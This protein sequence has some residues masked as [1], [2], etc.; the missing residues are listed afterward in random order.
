MALGKRLFTE[1]AA[2]CSTETTDIFG[3]STGKV[4]YSMDFDASSADRSLDATATNV[5]FGVSGRTVNAA[6]FKADGNTSKIDLPDILPA[7]SNADSSFTCWFRT[8]DT[9]GTQQTIVNAWN[10]STTANNGGWALFKD[11][12]NTFFFG[13]YYLKSNASGLTG[14]TALGDGNWH[15]VAVIFDYSAGTLS[16]YLD[17]NSTPHLQ[18]TSLTPGTVNIFN[19]GAELGY[20]KPGP[21]D[22]AFIGDIDQVRVFSKVLSQSEMDTLYNSGNG[23][24]ACVH[25]AT[26]DNND[27]P[28]TNAAYYK[29]N[30]S[31]E[32]SHSGTYDGTE[33]DIQYRFGKYNQAAVFNG[34]SSLIA[35]GS[36]IPNTDT[37]VAIS[38]W[39]K[40][41]SGISGNMHITGTGITTAASEAPFRATLQYQ[42]ANTFRLFAL[43]QVGGTYYLADNSTLTNVTMIPQIWYHVV[44][45]YN[46]TGRQLSTFLNG[47][48][49]DSNK[50]MSTSGSSVDDSTTVIGSFRSTSGP[51]FD[52]DIDQL[53]IFTSELS[54]T[55]VTSLYNEKPE[56]DT[57]NFKTVLYK[58]TGTTGHFINNVGM[59][60]ETDGG[61]VWIKSR[62]DSLG[63]NHILQ[64]HVRGVS[65]FIMTPSTSAESASDMVTS[66]EKTG[67]FLGADTPTGVNTNNINFV[68]WVWKAGGAT[69]ENTIGDITSQV[70]LNSTLG[71]SI[72]SYTGDANQSNTIGHG[73]KIG[74]TATRP[75]LIIVKN[76]TAT[77]NPSIMV[78]S[79]VFSS[80]SE[81]LLLNSNV[82]SNAITNRFG[83]ITTTT[84][85][86]GTNGNNEV[87]GANTMI[88]YCFASVTGL[89]KISSYTG[90]NSSNLGITGVGFQPSFLAIKKVS[91]STTGHWMV[92]DNRRDTTNAPQTDTCLFWNLIDE[93][94]TQSDINVRFDSNGFTLLGNNNNINENGSVFLYLAYK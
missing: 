59:D 45:S 85:K 65:N 31:A 8:S 18:H 7:N 82:L 12:G 4:L 20:Q 48:A 49:I 37:D 28:I 60:L 78:W 83:T 40:L 54:S 34:S 67:F 81:G 88:A 71:F 27:F 47:V 36:P 68:A 38:A 21:D 23:E 53:R 29:F 93:D 33:T 55:N 84:F 58:G 79:S 13:Q 74:T 57:S 64:D 70:S 51:F 5:D 2:A 43:R 25:S 15:F 77:N 39:V 90:D 22:R 73:L 86:G 91:G 89:S 14:G 6:R 94:F 80:S 72:V 76:R 26:T 63:D 50:A 87:N 3:G 44:W 24:T 17:G 32:D 52:G 1:G 66:F 9:S 16:L 42:S 41:N 62:N 69:S 75:D 11:A 61:L 56:T 46:S 92:Y 35:I 30:N 10:G 19:G